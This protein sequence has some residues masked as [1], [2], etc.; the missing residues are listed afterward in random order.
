VPRSNFATSSWLEDPVY[1]LLE[2]KGV[3]LCVAE[4]EKLSTPVEIT[5]DYAYFRLRDEG[6]T[7]QDLTRW[8]ETVQDAYLFLQGRICVL[9]ARGVGY[10]SRFRAH[11]PRR[12]RGRRARA[13]G[14][15]G[16]QNGRLALYLVMTF[17]ITWVCWWPLASLI[18]SGSGVFSN[19]TFIT[20]YLVGGL[21][22][23]LAAL[24]A[25]AFT[26]HEGSLAV[27]RGKPHPLARAARLVRGGVP[28]AAHS[29]LHPRPP[30]G[31]V[32]QRR[33]LPSRR[34]ATSRAYR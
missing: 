18:P 15:R 33:R 20:L 14:V 25:V 22:P 1:R 4:S 34:F 19:P 21:G 31:V 17:G 10:G 3:A 8:A 24:L 7:P 9:Q 27:I 6:Y 11:L 28:L 26:P 2:S 13:F 32:R 29:G 16:E 30:R 12:A 5:A 23:T